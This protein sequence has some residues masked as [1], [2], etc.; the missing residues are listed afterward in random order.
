[1]EELGIKLEHI[2][3]FC[4]SQSALH[5]TKCQVYHEIIKHIDVRLHFVS[6]EV[7]NMEKISTEDNPPDM[8]T[9]ALLM[10]KFKHCLD[11]VN[12]KTR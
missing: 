7:I 4:D 11:L 1:M 12:V 5:L 9:K 3:V 8:L 6:R 2:K 10:A